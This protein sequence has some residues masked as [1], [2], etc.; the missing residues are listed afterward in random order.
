MI[1]ER[2]LKWIY[3]KNLK[4]LYYLDCYFDRKLIKSLSELLLS[5]DDHDNLGYDYV[6]QQYNP[7]QYLRSRSLKTLVDNEHIVSLS[8]IVKY[9]HFVYEMAHRLLLGT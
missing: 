3:R 7:R 2:I 4:R 6:N 1:I 5:L 8:H 9:D